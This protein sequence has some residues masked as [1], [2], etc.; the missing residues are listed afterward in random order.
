MYIYIKVRDFIN[1]TFAFQMNSLRLFCQRFSYHGDFFCNV[2]ASSVNPQRNKAATEA[3][4]VRAVPVLVQASSWRWQ[5]SPQKE[6]L[7]FTRNL[8]ANPAPLTTL[9]QGWV[10]N[11]VG[12]ITLGW[13]SIIK[14]M[15]KVFNVRPFQLLVLILVSQETARNS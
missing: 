13:L 5:R 9:K 11:Q 7:Y 1:N 15:K 3:R 8:K 12:W 6:N 10:G 14:Y 4:S 2:P